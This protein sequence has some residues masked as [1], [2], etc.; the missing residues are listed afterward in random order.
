M[1]ATNISSHSSC[2]RSVR[3]PFNFPPSCP[4]LCLSYFLIRSINRKPFGAFS[5]L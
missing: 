4:P 5:G 2:L 1:P 3:S